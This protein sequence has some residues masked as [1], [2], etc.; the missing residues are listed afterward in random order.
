MKEFKEDIPT[1]KAA[2]DDTNAITNTTIPDTSSNSNKPLLEPLDKAVRARGL[3]E[4]S[5]N[6]DKSLPS[7]PKT[8]TKKPI[9]S[10]N[11]L[12]DHIWDGNLGADRRQ[13]SQSARPTTRDIFEG[14]LYTPKVKLGPRPS[15]DYSQGHSSGSITRS[16]EPRPVSTL[17]AGLAMS[18][19]KSTME[20]PHTQHTF[21]TPRFIE[22]ARMHHLTPISK[23]PSTA[24]DR[25]TSKAGSVTSIPTYAYI[26]DVKPST[27][28]PEKQRLMKALQMR[29][30]Q[31][32]RKN[33]E[34]TPPAPRSTPSIG[35]PVP[36]TEGQ[37]HTSKGFDDGTKSDSISDPVHPGVQE[38]GEGS[39]A[40]SSTS[41]ASL[42]DT[43]DEL[44]T[45]ASSLAEP[46]ESSIE[47]PAS[48]NMIKANLRS[49]DD[50]SQSFRKEQATLK[51]CSVQ[52]NRQSV[53]SQI[54]HPDGNHDLLDKTYQQSYLPNE[55]SHLSELV[56]STLIQSH[57][58]MFLPYQIPLPVA[59][60]DEDFLLQTSPISPVLAPRSSVAGKSQTIADEC[61][62]PKLVNNLDKPAATP[63]ESNPR[64]LTTDSTDSHSPE[65]KSRRRGPVEPIRI[66]S[67]ADQSEENFLSDESFMEELQSATVQEAK[68]ISVSRSPV[69]PLVPMSPRS[70]SISRS[71]DAFK[72]TRTSSNPLDGGSPQKQN[73]LTTDVI[74]TN[75]SPLKA[76]PFETLSPQRAVSSP[77][78]FTATQSERQ[79]SPKSSGSIASRTIS[80][81]PTLMEQIDPVSASLSKRTGV[82][83]LISQRIKALEKSSSSGSQAPSPTAVVTPT[84]V[85]KRKDSSSTTPTAL[86]PSDTP[87]ITNTWKARRDLPYPTPSPSPHSTIVT[88]KFG[89]SKVNQATTPTHN[90]PQPDSIVVPASIGHDAVQQHAPPK[91]LKQSL[92]PKTSSDRS[93]SS[94]S[95]EAK[96]D[97]RSASR[98]DSVTSKR[99]T[100]SRKEN[101]DVGPS[102]SR[103]S[104]DGRASIDGFKEDKKESRKNRLFKRMS[105][106]TSTS[107]RN[108]AQALGASVKE[109]PIVERQEPE[110]KPSLVNIDFG[111]LNVQFP[112]TLV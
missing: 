40:D 85:T 6:L 71:S 83:S 110:I 25:P 79:L 5:I 2:I 100:S 12:E 29:K 74:G 46:D 92:R 94:M 81:S 56:A 47:Q 53:V 1:V 18:S 39:N 112:D 38:I 60:K 42:H 10:H 21:S 23:A 97:A 86:S 87:V 8:T 77:V 76:M 102:L 58:E 14:Q 80:T 84:L 52:D 72:L 62:Q 105:A 95:P 49:P 3:S 20:R 88:R 101:A 70:I 32:E 37:E 13:S 90:K 24:S 36:G 68:P 30:K 111:D 28:T 75:Y 59:D 50:D 26:S 107:R 54:H 73:P 16:I 103:S 89:S 31:M 99:S 106:I 93:D 35:I 96:P 69:T 34:V 65:R 48:D 104:S 109:E 9:S 78:D 27:T 45:K 61:P 51:D 11:P 22:N 91:V 57:V 17:P 43:L 64:P 19:R 66:V 108:I 98:R 41:P 4:S 33:L 15:L 44:S 63:D 67:N 55:T 7:I 82:S